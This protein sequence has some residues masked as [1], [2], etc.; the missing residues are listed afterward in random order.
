MWKP[1]YRN[2]QTKLSKIIERIFHDQTEEFLS[3][4]KL[5]YKFQSDVRKNYSTNTCLGYLTDKILTGFE[6]GIF[7]RMILIDLKKSFDTIE[8]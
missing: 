7:T 1:S 8:H 4:E 6:K 2:Q 3:K 5:L